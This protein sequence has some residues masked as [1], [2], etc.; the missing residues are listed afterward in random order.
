M[1]VVELIV[2]SDGNTM[3]T[4]QDVFVTLGSVT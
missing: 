4:V 3:E 2:D 1:K